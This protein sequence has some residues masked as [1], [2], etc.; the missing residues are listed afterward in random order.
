MDR[1]ARRSVAVLPV[2]SGPVLDPDAPAVGDN[3]LAAYRESQSGAARARPRRV[4]AAEALKHLL[5]LSAA[6]S[7]PGVADT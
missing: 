5:T 1:G 2:V 7:G 4:L 6:D 3:D